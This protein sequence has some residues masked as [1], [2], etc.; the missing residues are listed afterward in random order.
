MTTSCDRD[1]VRLCLIGPTG[2]GKSTIAKFVAR[3]Y[4]G[5]VLKIAEPLYDLQQSF[6]QKIGK[7]IQGQDGEL[8]QFLGAKVEQENPGWLSSTFMKKVVDSNSRII[9]NDDCRP[10]SYETLSAGGFSFV[11]IKTDPATRNARARAD[12]ISVD[13]RHPVERGFDDLRCDYEIDNNGDFDSTRRQIDSLMN[14]LVGALHGWLTGNQIIEEH[15]RGAITIEPFS[16]NCINANS[17][18]Y[19]ISP[20][21]HRITSSTVDF[22]EPDEY[23][24]ITMDANGYVLKPFELY[25]GSTVERFGSNVFASLITGRSSVGRKFVTNHITAGLIDQGFFGNVTLEIVVHRPTK[26]YPNIK[27]GQIFWFSTLG[28][29][30]LYDGKYKEQL[31][32]VRSKIHDDD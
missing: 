2:S 22:R 5:E 27:F 30:R 19:H 17:Y 26:I 18:N 13:E 7:S 23:E 20:T 11:R 10:H 21:L 29:P 9:V 4:G 1:V 24:V 25:L 6:Y 15:R 14:T 3:H 32:P 12:H 31:G 16:L 28:L 8:L